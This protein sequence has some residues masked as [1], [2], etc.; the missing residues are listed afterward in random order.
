MLFIK[1]GQTS[2]RDES[3]D[4]IKRWV[5]RWEQHGFGLWAAELVDEGRLAGFVGLNIPKEFPALLPA[6]E[7]GWRIDRALWGQGYATEGG[8][9]SVEFA[10]GELGLDRVIAIIH[11]E[12]VASVRVAEKLG[13]APCGTTESEEAGTVRV[14]EL[15]RAE[16]AWS[17]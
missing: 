17:R 12:N 5:S 2:T 7:V 1:G 14:F 16:S 3:A 13:M 9:A 11:A 6:V 4:A 8:R 10:F 15:L